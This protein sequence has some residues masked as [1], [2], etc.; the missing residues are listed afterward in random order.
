[1]ATL[2][3]SEALPRPAR[4]AYQV[5]RITFIVL[6]IV[7]GI[8]QFLNKLT[9][10]DMYLAPF[11]TR[12]VPLSA[13]T[14]MA[15]AGAVEILAGLLVAFRPRI[16]AWLVAVWLWMIV[17]NLLVAGSF[18]DTALRDLA[19]SCGAVALALLAPGS[20]RD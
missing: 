10:W 8:D 9:N 16:G 13:H 12:L 17:I 18:Y 6:P 7:T 11:A 2:A 15:L 1:M 4:Q 20:Q 3:D 19:L 5:L 14:I